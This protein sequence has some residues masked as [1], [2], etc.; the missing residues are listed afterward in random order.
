[1]ILEF[2][3][4]SQTNWR[5]MQVALCSI[6]RMSA[7]SADEELLVFYASNA[8]PVLRDEL[9]LIELELSTPQPVALLPQRFRYDR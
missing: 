6:I 8:F 1:M 5:E 4:R 7:F 2:S 3:D 9:A